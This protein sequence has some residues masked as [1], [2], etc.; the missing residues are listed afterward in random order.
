MR[1]IA[2]SEGGARPGRTGNEREG[3]GAEKE[4]REGRENCRNLAFFLPIYLWFSSTRAAVGRS[5]G[6][7]VSFKCAALVGGMV[8]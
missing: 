3:V 4:K 6:P 7:L 5:V 2:S 1:V 8:A